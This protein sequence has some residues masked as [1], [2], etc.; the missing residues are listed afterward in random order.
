MRGLGEV[1]L[2]TLS[3]SDYLWFCGEEILMVIKGC[4]QGVAANLLELLSRVFSQI[5]G[6][7]LY[8]YHL[9]CHHRQCYCVDVIGLG[10][11]FSEVPHM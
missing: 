2:K 9:H 8:H 10:S 1:V 5:I 11:G 6:N 4:L 3:S 7:L